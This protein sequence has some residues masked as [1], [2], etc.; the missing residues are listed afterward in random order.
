M[1]YICGE[2]NQKINTLN[3]KQLQMK[4]NITF[5]AITFLFLA[6]SYA[7]DTLPYTL[8]VLEGTYK[9]LE[10]PTIITNGPWDDFDEGL[11]EFPIGFDFTIFGSSTINQLRIGGGLPEALAAYNEADGTYFL[12][13]PCYGDLVSSFDTTTLGFYPLSY[14]TTGAPGERIFKQEWRHVG[15]YNDD[16]GVSFI[17]FQVWLYEATGVIEYHYGPSY[18]TE[19]VSFLYDDGG[20]IVGLISGLDQLEDT[21]QIGLLLSGDPASP[22]LLNPPPEGDPVFLTGQPADGTIYRFTPTVTIGTNDIPESLPLGLYPVPATHSVTL[23]IGDDLIDKGY[24]ITD[25]TGRVILEKT[26]LSSKTIDIST[27]RPGVYFVR[28]TNGGTMVG[29][30]RFNKL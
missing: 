30:G 14:E 5:L 29:V 13:A 28:L 23:E 6:R 24:Q 4:K 21:Y 17:N 7:Q 15:F 18:L 27:L 10:K 2:N 3:S 16:S 8:E 11:F 12:I 25:I 20:P 9:N 1:C 26:Q 22:T 19:S